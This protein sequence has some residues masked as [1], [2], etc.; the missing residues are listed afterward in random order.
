MKILIGMTRS[1]T[2]ASGS[3]KHICQIGDRFREEGVDVAYVLG[4]N[5]PAAH[6][7][8]ERGYR[9][10][11]LSSL[12]RNL[13]FW[14]DFFALIQLLAVILKFR[15][16]L[17]SWHTAKIGAIGRFAS[18][19]TFRRNYYVPHGVP[20]VNTAENKGYRKFQILERLLSTLPGTIIG[21]CQFDKNE[22]VRI[23]VPDGKVKVILNGMPGESNADCKRERNSGS[24]VKF[25]T[26]ARFEA[27]KDYVTLANAVNLLYESGA[28]FRLDIYGDGFGEDEVRALFSKIPSEIV[29]FRGVVDDF[30]KRLAESDVYLL[31]SHWE[32]LPRSIVEAMACSKAVIA[33]DVGGCNELINHELSGYLVP[34]KDVLA[35]YGSMRFYIDDKEKV[36]LHGRNGHSSYISNFTL[37]NMLDQYVNEYLGTGY[38]RVKRSGETV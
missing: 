35:L 3:F 30:S 37:A 27:Q 22:Y 31:S 8:E 21:V 2:I 17:C 25:I 4:G 16:N 24:P 6:T 5:G 15:P 32:G 9:V 7:L 10:Y 34:H 38:A 19:L 36:T 26:A 33:T 1:D 13:N 12:T 23:G 28:D 29:S 18:L 14:F 20:F 11:K